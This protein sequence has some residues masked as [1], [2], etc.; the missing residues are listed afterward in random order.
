MVV[1]PQCYMALVLAACCPR[2]S[3]GVSL[4]SSASPSFVASLSSG[5]LTSTG[6]SL[7][8]LSACN[9][10]N[11]VVSTLVNT[12]E[13]LWFIALNA[14]QAGAFVTGASSWFR[15]ST[16]SQQLQKI[17]RTDLLCAGGL[18]VSGSDFFVTDACLGLVNRT[19]PDG[20]TAILAGG[21]SPPPYS[22]FAGGI[23]TNAVFDTPIGIVISSTGLLYV[24]DSGNGLIRSVNLLGQTHILVGDGRNSIPVDGIGT[25]ALFMSPRALAIDSFD[26]LYASDGSLIRRIIVAKQL[27]TTLAGSTTN[28]QKDGEA[29]LA[30]FGYIMSI[31]VS[32]DSRHIYV[33]DM[34][35]IENGHPSNSK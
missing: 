7:S 30:L 3:S 32:T 6:P 8:T 21:G 17:G 24:S 2:V 29:S 25:N 5:S 31:A 9:R 22:T 15:G 18:A 33:V 34:Y 4:T 12:T 14:S 23:G 19:T 16:S 10:S 11:A 28:G 13:Q 20:V 1:L 35:Y 26:V 27:M